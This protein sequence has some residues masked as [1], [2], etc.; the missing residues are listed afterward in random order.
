M[1]DTQ[2]VST[3]P[4]GDESDQDTVT[5][6]FTF[7]LKVFDVAVK[8]PLEDGYAEEPK[9]DTNMQKVLDSRNRHPFR[10]LEYR[11]V[12]FKHS[13]Y[14]FS[15]KARNLRLYEE[16][17]TT[18]TEKHFQLKTPWACTGEFI[19]PNPESEQISSINNVYQNEIL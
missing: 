1:T 12:F 13:A 10:V 11:T 16:L 9:V 7:R 5:T 14:E 6:G 15:F 2:T 8:A 3:H 18:S 17:S 4:V 19:Q